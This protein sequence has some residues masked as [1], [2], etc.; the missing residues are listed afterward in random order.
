MDL[1]E[2]EAAAAA[3][4]S[5]DDRV[6]TAEGASGS[7]PMGRGLAGGAVTP[8]ARPVIPPRAAG[9]DMPDGRST[10]SIGA[11]SAGSRAKL[12]T[13]ARLWESMRQ[14]FDPARE[15]RSAW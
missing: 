10:R 5:D 6:A 15:E 9:H 1:V 4:D 14:E 7:N 11:G 12:P 3:E 2:L 8:R 13:A